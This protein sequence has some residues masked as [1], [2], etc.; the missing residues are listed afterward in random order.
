[1]LILSVYTIAHCG[2]VE[3]R[4]ERLIPFVAGQPWPYCSGMS[5]GLKGVMTARTECVN[6][7]YSVGLHHEGN[8]QL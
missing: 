1:M 7:A 5:E 2:V 4:M 3:G 8:Y 6:Y